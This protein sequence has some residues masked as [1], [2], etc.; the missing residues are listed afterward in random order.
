MSAWQLPYEAADDIKRALDLLYE[1]ETGTLTGNDIVDIFNM[2]D[3]LK[4]LDCIKTLAR[5]MV[6]HGFNLQEEIN[7]Q[8]FIEMLE[9]VLHVE[10]LKNTKGRNHRAGD[11]TGNV[12]YTRVRLLSTMIHNSDLKKVSGTSAHHAQTKLKLRV[13]TNLNSMY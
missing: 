8:R 13:N 7:G 2:H 3:T 11:Q 5:Y 6:R 12:S 1:V 4:D 10:I 9:C